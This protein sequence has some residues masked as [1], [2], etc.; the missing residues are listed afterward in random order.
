[1]EV[2]SAVHNNLKEQHL[3]QTS[4]GTEQDFERTRKQPGTRFILVI[5]I[6]VFGLGNIRFFSIDYFFYNEYP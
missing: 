2:E 4:E 3:F 6:E 5:R 1:M